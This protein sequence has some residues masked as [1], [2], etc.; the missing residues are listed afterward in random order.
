MVKKRGREGQPQGRGVLRK[1]FFEFYALLSSLGDAFVLA[2]RMRY[3]THN[4][5]LDRHLPFV[6]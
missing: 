6:M 2:C 5:L 3:Q 1:L 4:R